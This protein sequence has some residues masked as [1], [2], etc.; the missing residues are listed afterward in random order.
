MSTMRTDTRESG[1]FE[2][3]AFQLFLFTSFEKKNL[4]KL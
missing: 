3:F 4:N 1:V 2:V